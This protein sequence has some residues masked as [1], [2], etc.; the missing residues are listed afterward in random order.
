[1]GHTTKPIDMSPEM[2]RIATERRGH[3]F[4]MS[5]D[6]PKK[7]NGFT[8]KMLLELAQAYAA[9]ENDSELWCA[10]LQAEGEHFTAGLQLSE[11]TI[12]DPL[13]PPG[14][15]DPLGLHP[16]FRSKPVVVAVH[17][18]CY[19]IGIELML[20]ADIVIAEQGTRFGQ[21][22]VKRGLMAYGGA[23][24]RMVERAGWG[25]AMK[26]LLTGDDFNAE[27]ALRYN[28]VQELV[29]K[30][31]AKA[32]AFALAER[33]AKQAPV[34][35]QET[36]RSSWIYVTQGQTAAVAEFPAQLARVA[37]TQDFNEGVKSFVERREAVF[38]GK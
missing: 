8:P 34:A 6:R 20:A 17:G 5:I 26:L 22:E 7:Y 30:G 37:T 24:I 35:V 21:V 36:R 14:V 28:F 11:F 23:T 38:K 19:T 31:E 29:A 12:S 27:E 25:N 13:L 2:G 33:I 15:I 10:V 9:F 32:R 3:V 16:P 4:V 18:I 1:M